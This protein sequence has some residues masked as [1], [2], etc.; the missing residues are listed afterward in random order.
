MCCECLILNLPPNKLIISTIIGPCSVCFSPYISSLGH[1]I[2][3]RQTGNIFHPSILPTYIQLLTKSVQVQH[4]LWSV[5]C[6]P[7][8]WQHSGQAL[9]HLCPALLQQTYTTNAPSSSSFTNNKDL[10]LNPKSNYSPDYNVDHLFPTRK[11]NF[12]PYITPMSLHHLT[13]AIISLQFFLLKSHGQLM[14][15]PLPGRAGVGHSSSKLWDHDLHLPGTPFSYYPTQK[16]FIHP[17]E[18]KEK[19]ISSSHHLQPTLSLPFGFYT[20]SYY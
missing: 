5:S 13:L 1:S 6:S 17:S 8:L 2:S 4:I 10:L 15:M 18:H 11:A 7:S 16:M 14:L 19:I 12:I 9:H 20:N 3:S